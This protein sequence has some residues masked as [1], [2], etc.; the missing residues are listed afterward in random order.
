MPLT[1]RRTCHLVDL[2]SPHNGIPPS[3]GEKIDREHLTPKQ[4][5]SPDLK[6]DG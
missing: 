4:K 3:H 5:I 6:S 2:V 1:V